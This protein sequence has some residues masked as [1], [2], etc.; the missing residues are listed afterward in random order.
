[1]GERARSRT[2]RRGAGGKFVAG[3]QAGFLAA[4]AARTT[5]S[6]PA[7]RAVRPRPAI[8]ITFLPSAYG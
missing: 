1:M 4:V 3:M 5:T 7:R 2:A 8:R 6:E